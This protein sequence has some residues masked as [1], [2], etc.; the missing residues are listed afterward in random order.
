MKLS[1]YNFYLGYKSN[2][3]IGVIKKEDLKINKYIC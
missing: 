3:S 1:K 2:K